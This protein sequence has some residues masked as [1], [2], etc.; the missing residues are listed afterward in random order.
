MACHLDRS[1]LNYHLERS[2]IKQY[3]H[4]R[5]LPNHARWILAKNIRSLRASARRRKG[6]PCCGS[7]ILMHYQLAYAV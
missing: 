6:Y 2:V 7:D 5:V 3:N 4:K 1:V